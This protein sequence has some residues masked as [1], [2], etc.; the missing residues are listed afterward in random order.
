VALDNTKKSIEQQLLSFVPDHH[1][2]QTPFDIYGA[3]EASSM[4]KPL[5]G[6][7]VVVHNLP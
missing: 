7:D 1:Y 5:Q 6:L 3:L 2:Q 4:R